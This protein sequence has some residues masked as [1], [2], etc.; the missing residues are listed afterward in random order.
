VIT[1]LL[2]IPKDSDFF[3]F[4]PRQTGKTTLIENSFDSEQVFRIN[5]LEHDLYL[6]Y[7]LSPQT[8]SEEIV[9]LAS[10]SHIFID[11]IQR[12][13]ELLNQVQTL[14]DK[15]VSQKFILTGSSARK[16]KKIQANLLGGRAWSLQ[17]Y[18][19]SYLEVSKDFNLIKVLEYG[20]LPKIFLEINLSNKYELL[21]SY[22][23]TYLEVEIKSESLVRNLQTF[24]NFLTIAAQLNAE[25]INYSN[26]ASETG[27]S[28]YS[29]QEYYSILQDTLIGKML[30]PY[31]NSERKKHKQAP[32]FY[33][34]DTGVCRAIQQKL[35][36]PLLPK[37]FE[38]GNMFETFFINEVFKINSY[39]RKDW[40]LGFLRTVNNVE[41][42]LIIETPLGSVIAIEIKSKE[43]PQPQDYKS[44]IEALK[45]ITKHFTFYCA[46][47]GKTKRTIENANIWPFEDVL[48]MLRD[49]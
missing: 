47:T 17:L 15:K 29:T 24:I 37:S 1:R 48:T 38:Y 40:K 35:K 31:H 41:V 22:I 13:P 44:G 11:E 49:I 39:F 9:N 2:T 19:L 34:F 6:K 12:V 4:G 28:R 21:R 36:A 32:K 16:L 43:L 18:P 8:L 5:L 14:I 30:L 7:L 20:L 42:D 46:C 27:A 25:Q 45:K 10:K 3:L 26:I 33:F 23:E